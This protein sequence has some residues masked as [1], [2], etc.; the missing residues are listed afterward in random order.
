MA[1]VSD[2]YAISS[3]GNEFYDLKDGEYGFINSKSIY[4]LKNGRKIEPS[5]YLQDEDK[6]SIE[7]NNKTF[8]EKE[9]QETPLKLKEMYSKYL[10]DTKLSIDIRIK[11]II[12]NSS[13]IVFVGCGSSFHAC[14]IAGY[15][16]SSIK[17]TKTYL[18]SEF[19]EENTITPGDVYILIS[20]SGETQDVIKCLK[21]LKNYNQ[22]VISLTN[23]IHSSI[24]KEST[25]SLP[26]YMVKEISVASTKA[27]IGEV[28]LLLLL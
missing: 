4:V 14:E 9:I 15:Y 8:F 16:Y 11:Q 25:F 13:R 5:F 28:S 24:A 12:S 7:N 10:E 18:A 22:I 2:T 17:N 1:I 20:Q 27:F 23:N 21:Y 19:I 6:C 26:L 3:F